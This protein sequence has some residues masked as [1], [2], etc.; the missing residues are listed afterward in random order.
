MKCSS[1]GSFD[2]R[3]SKRHSTFSFFN[4]IKGLERYRCREC[5]HSFWEKPPSSNSE[6]IRRKRARAWSPFF[7]TRGRRAFIEV[8]LFV[9]ML[10]VFFFTIRYLVSKSEPP[11]PVGS[12]SPAAVS[13][14]VLA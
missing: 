8:T 6:K 14:G 9:A 4:Q 11:G 10:V 3:L 13:L 1:C 12:V 2:V 5:R 7:Q